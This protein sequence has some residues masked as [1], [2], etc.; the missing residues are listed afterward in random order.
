MKTGPLVCLIPL[1]VIIM[2]SCRPNSGSSSVSI[3]PTSYKDTIFSQ[4]YHEGYPLGRGFDGDVRSIAVD[5]EDNVWIATREGVFRKSKDE[6]AWL[7]VL[8]K[9]EQGP[10]FDEVVREFRLLVGDVCSTNAHLQQR[11][12]RVAGR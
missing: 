10:S 7:P 12:C 6:Q 9:E 1:L 5:L 11:R 4:E 3:E 2:G 8:P